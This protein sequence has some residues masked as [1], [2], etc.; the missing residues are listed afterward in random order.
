MK[1]RGQEWPGKLEIATKEGKS[2]ILTIF[3]L[4]IG[5]FVFNT[6]LAV[7]VLIM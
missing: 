3:L 5:G 6:F 7:E 4:I 1:F 2:I